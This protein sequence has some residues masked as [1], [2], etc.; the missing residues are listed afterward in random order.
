MELTTEQKNAMIKQRLEQYSMQIFS[1]QM[2]REALQAAGD[3]VGVQT[4]DKRIEK[5]QTAYSAVERM[6]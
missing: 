4:T 5:L 6:I 2:D 3:T 1:L